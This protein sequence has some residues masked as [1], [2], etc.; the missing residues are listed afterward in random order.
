MATTSSVAAPSSGALNKIVLLAVALVA[1]YF[2]YQYI[3][4]YFVWSEQS[5]GYYWP[6]RMSLAFH[7]TGGTVALLVGVFQLWSGINRRA[8]ST[9]PWTGRLY[10]AGVAVGSLGAITLSITSALYGFAWALSLFSLAIAWLAITGTA[11]YCIR[12]RNLIAHKQWMTRSYIL[13]FAFVTFR[14]IVDYVPYEAAWGISTQEM[15]VA[16][17]WPIWVMP[18]L[19]YEI[20]LQLRR[21]RA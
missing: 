3:P 12:R 7:V 10:V 19:A 9:H 21:S 18:L 15:S 2:A 11:I 4:N 14:I 8:M 5:Y 20:A 13:T 1:A 17:I 16:I 6:F